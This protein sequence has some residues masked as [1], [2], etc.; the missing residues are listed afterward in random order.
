M[1]A[2]PLIPLGCCFT[3]DDRSLR[4][5][6][7]E[8]DGPQ[9]G[10]ARDSAYDAGKSKQ[11]SGTVG[12][13]RRVPLL[14]SD[15]KLCVVMESELKVCCRGIGRRTSVRASA[16]ASGGFEAHAFSAGS[17]TGLFLTCAKY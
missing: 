5:G 10:G 16:M 14:M 3:M 9:P 2:A 7:G 8:C 6:A 17:P 4:R 12:G 15:V 11:A 1:Q 13:E